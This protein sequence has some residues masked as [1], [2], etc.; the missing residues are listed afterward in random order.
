MARR[1]TGGRLRALLFLFISFGAAAVASVVIYLVIASYQNELKEVTAPTEVVKVMVASHDI[2]QGKTIQA[3]DLVMVELPPSYVPDSVLRQIDQAVGRVPRER[4]LAHEFIRDERLADP[5]AGV[6]LNAIIPRGMRAMSL[7][8]SDGSSVSGFLNPGNYVDVLVT[9][10]GDD[11]G[12]EAETVTLLQAVTVLAVNN[13]LGDSTAGEGSKKPSVTL[14]V[15]PDLAEKLTHAVAQGTV[16]LTLRND[17]DVTHVETHGAIVQNLLGGQ[18][19]SMRITVKE[20]RQRS[21]ASTSQQVIMIMGPESTKETI[22]NV[23]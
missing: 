15:T 23:P 8:I 22:K 13:R 16:T 5:A 11:D 14:A 17:I 10:E 9:I 7:D 3:E 6:G 2:W 18:D 19:E 1:S 4:I 20:W 21:A 12:R